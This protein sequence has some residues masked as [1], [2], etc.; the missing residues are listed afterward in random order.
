MFGVIAIISHYTDASKDRRAIEN[1]LKLLK[2]EHDQHEKNKELKTTFDDSTVMS[3]A[4]VRAFGTHSWFSVA[5]RHPCDNVSSVD[6]TWIAYTGLI[7]AAAITIVFTAQPDDDRD[8]TLLFILSSIYGGLVA[9]AVT[10]V[11]VWAFPGGSYIRI[12]RLHKEL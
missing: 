12:N 3:R 4:F 11:V 6:R 7:S 2:D 9:S 5:Y 10:E 1:L 8:P